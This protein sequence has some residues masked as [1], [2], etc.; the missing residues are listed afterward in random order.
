LGGGAGVVICGIVFPNSAV[1]IGGGETAK[2][3]GLIVFGVYFLLAGLF[4][5]WMKCKSNKCG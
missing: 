2:A 4:G 5:L 1:T 3:S